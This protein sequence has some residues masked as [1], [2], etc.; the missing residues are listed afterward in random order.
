[1]GKTCNF[2]VV[3]KCVLTSGKYEY[4]S[5]FIFVDKK[6]LEGDAIQLDPNKLFATI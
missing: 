5:S 3:V 4:F 2:L 1:M 6:K